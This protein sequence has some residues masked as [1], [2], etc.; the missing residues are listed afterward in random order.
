MCRLREALRRRGVRN[1]WA[2][3]PESGVDEEDEE[4]EGDDEVNAGEEEDD[5]MLDMVRLKLPNVLTQHSFCAKTCCLA[6]DHSCFPAGS[7]ILSVTLQEE[8]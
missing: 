7:V 6:F 4:G 2:S 5:D 8:H 1:I 3:D